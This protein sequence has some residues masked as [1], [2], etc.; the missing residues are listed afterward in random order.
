MQ[1]ISSGSSFEDRVGYSRAV[2][3]NGH[4]F[5]SAT[6]ATG[7]GGEILH[8]GDYYGQSKAILEKLGRLL[9]DVG[10][11]IDRVVQTKVYVVD[12]AE[13]EAVGR[14]HAEA[15][16]LQRPAFTILHVN[17]F[18]HPDILVEVELTAEVVHSQP[19]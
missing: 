2:V 4:V 16:S 7:E 19:T 15:F 9:A 11:S 3:S 10:S 1:R 17:R 13:W 18:L 12:I 14:A 5:V 8:L 6:A